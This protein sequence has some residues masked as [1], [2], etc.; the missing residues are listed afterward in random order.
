MNKKQMIEEILIKARAGGAHIDG[1]MF[2]ALAF[3][4]EDE[5]RGIC[6]EIGIPVAGGRPNTK[7]MRI[8]P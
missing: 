2:F 6:R 3:R 4:T 7:K 5:L 8:N 1:D